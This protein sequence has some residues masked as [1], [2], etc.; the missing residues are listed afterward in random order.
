MRC[1]KCGT[2]ARNFAPSAGAH[3]RIAVRTIIR[4]TQRVLIAAV[5]QQG[6]GGRRLVKRGP[7]RR[8]KDFVVGCLERRYSLFEV[9]G[10]RRHGGG[11]FLRSNLRVFQ[12]GRIRARCGRVAVRSRCVPFMSPAGGGSVLGFREGFMGS[13]Q[14]VTQACWQRWAPPPVRPVT[15]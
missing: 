2:P 3:R 8:V 1:A 7:L 12:F 4:T 13:L 5:P 6:H 15:A 11:R 10:I 9:A 14:V